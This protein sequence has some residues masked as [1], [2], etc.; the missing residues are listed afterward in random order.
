MNLVDL[1]ILILLAL[2]GLVGYVRGLVR[3]ALGLA[4]WGGALFIASPLGLFPYV[5]PVARRLV[6]DPALAD[7]AAFGAVFL[8]VLVLLWIVARVASDGVRASRLGGLDRTLGLVFGAAR[9]AVLV[10]VAYI[11]AGLAVPVDAWPVPVR[12]ARLLPAVHRGAAWLAGQLP[13]GYRP[14]VSPPPAGRETTAGALLHATPVGRAIPV[15][16]RE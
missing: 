7:P 2:S 4:A 16:R 8:V 14:A 12:E 1:A 6:A 3:E 15:R 13:P 10:V 5:Q 11:V 9:G